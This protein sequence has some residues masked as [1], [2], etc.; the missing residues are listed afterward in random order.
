MI[1]FLMVGILLGLAAGFAP[2]P[3]LTLVI[4]ETLAHDIKAGIKV[5]I[6]PFITDLPI[7]LITLFILSRLSHLNGVLAA[8]SFVG[9]CVLIYMGIGSM[10]AGN[11]TIELSGK[12]SNALFKGILVNFL[13]PHPYLFWISIGGPTS[14]K[15]MHHSL[16]AFLGFFIS[17]YFFLVASKVILAVI[18]GRSRSFLS[19][20]VYKAIMRA[21]GVA[22]CILAVLLFKEA[23]VLIQ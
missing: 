13:S 10:K 5:A 22:L 2:G 8:I 15:A 23:V 18:T 16:F 21:L 1:H 9:G 17:F 12:R 11:D 6:A 14:S 20:N 4:S 19:G 7:I 3:L